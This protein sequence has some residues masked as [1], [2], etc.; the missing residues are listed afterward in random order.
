M[1]DIKRILFVVLSL[2][3][4]FVFSKIKSNCDIR[5]DIRKSINFRVSRME[6]SSAHR[7]RYFDSKNKELKMSGFVFF[8][9]DSVKSGDSIA[10]KSNSRIMTVFRNKKSGAFYPF[11]KISLTSK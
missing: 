6:V 2:V 4:V 8:L 9:S 1:K 7:C 10:K 3:I 5:N 11:F